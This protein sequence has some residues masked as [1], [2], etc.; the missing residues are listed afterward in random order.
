[1]NPRY[2]IKHFI[3]RR[4]DDAIYEIPASAVRLVDAPPLRPGKIAEPR[5]PP[6]KDGP[7]AANPERAKDQCRPSNR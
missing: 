5:D 2:A 6:P 1:V 4:G 7:G 3:F